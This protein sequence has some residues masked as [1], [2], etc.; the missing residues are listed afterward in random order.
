MLS[1]FAVLLALFGRGRVRVYS[2]I[3]ALGRV[4]LVM[5]FGTAGLIIR[6][7]D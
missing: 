2:L 7:D 1:A 5:V 4:L 3:G 6:T